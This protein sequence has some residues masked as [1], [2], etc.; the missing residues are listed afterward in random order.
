MWLTRFGE[1]INRGWKEAASVA[2]IFSLIPFIGWV[3]IVILAFI[4]LRKGPQQG[5]I[6]LLVTALPSLLFWSVGTGFLWVIIVLSGNLLTWILAVVLRETSDWGKVLLVTLLFVLIVVTVV[7]LLVPDLQGYWYSILQKIY[8]EANKDVDMLMQVPPVN[9]KRYFSDMARMI[10]PMLILTQVLLAL[11][12]LL[13]A[14]WWQA[15]MFNP[16]GLGKELYQIRLSLWCSVI[17]LVTIIALYM[18]IPAGWDIL[19]ILIFMYFLVGVVVFHSL[20]EFR[21]AKTMWLWLFFGLVVLLF[22]YSF[23]IV[24]CLGIA[25]SF[26]DFR[27]RIA[28]S[29]KNGEK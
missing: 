27:A 14:R 24:A 12:N 29:L 6:I 4:T 9:A 7:H 25:D 22:P 19:P 23:V 8:A 16:G 5:L 2:L 11:T 3:G 10:M 1:Y 13:L 17:L 18:G 28:R 21:K 20:I 15:N 26:V